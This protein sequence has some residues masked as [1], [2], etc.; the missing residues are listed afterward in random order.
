VTLCDPHVAS[1]V[2]E[3]YSPRRSPSSSDRAAELNS[4]PSAPSGY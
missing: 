2:S 4:V 1:R 3:V